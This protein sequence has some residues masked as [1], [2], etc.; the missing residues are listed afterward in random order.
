[1]RSFVRSCLVALLTLAAAPPALAQQVPEHRPDAS[2][3]GEPRPDAEDGGRPQVLPNKQPDALLE[4]KKRWHTTVELALTIGTLA[5]GALVLG[6]L[7]VFLGKGL[8]PADVF[9]KL[10]V[11]V[12]VVTAGLFV[13]VAGYTEN[14][15]APMMGLLGTLVGYLLGREASRAA[16]KAGEPG[17]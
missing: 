8:L 14:Q 10:F 16:A 12:I 1:M 3:A 11:L 7:G 2:A 4:P 15:I 6:M 13:V 5:F 17:A 9:L